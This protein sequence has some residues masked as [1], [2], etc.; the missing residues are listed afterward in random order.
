MRKDKELKSPAALR[1]LDA[2]ALRQEAEELREHL[3][4]LRFQKETG[5]LEDAQVITFYRRALARVLTLLGE[6]E[7]GEVAS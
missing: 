5:A 4:K 3:M 1:E 6:K 2:A 7:R